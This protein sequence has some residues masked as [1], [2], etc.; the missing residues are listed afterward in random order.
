MYLE[1][2]NPGGGEVAKIEWRTMMEMMVLTKAQ[3]HYL[4]TSNTGGNTDG[5]PEER[6]TIVVNGYVGIG[7]TS[8]TEK[9]K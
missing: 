6:M 9:G 3:E 5:V 1:D 8:P 4:W 2:D 7:T